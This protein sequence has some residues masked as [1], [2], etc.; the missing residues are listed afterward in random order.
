MDSI[1]HVG[2]LNDPRIG[3]ACGCWGHGIPIGTHNGR[4]LAELM[5]NRD[6][7]STQAWFVSRAKRFWPSRRLAGLLA[8]GTSALKRRKLRRLRGI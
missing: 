3:Y 4:T 1:P 5:L 7:E 8:E 2:L 6:T